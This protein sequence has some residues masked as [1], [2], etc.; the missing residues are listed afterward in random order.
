VKKS[1]QLLVEK[2]N[3]A[4]FVKWAFDAELDEV[5]GRLLLVGKGSP[6]RFQFD[7][8]LTRGHIFKALYHLN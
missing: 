8:Q 2:G 6:L 1:Y 5:V 3:N 4:T 7:I